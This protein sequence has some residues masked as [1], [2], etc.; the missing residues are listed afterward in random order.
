MDVSIFRAIL[1]YAVPI[2]YAIALHEAAHGY[3]AR[4]FGDRTA[5]AQGRLTLNPIKHI[6]PVGTI[7]VPG[8]LLVMAMVT[9]GPMFLFGWAKPVPVV[10]RNLRNPRRDMAIVAAAGPISNLFMATIWAI[11]I[12]I[13]SATGVGSLA[14][15]ALYSMAYV[16]ILFNVVLAVFNMLPLPPLDGGR[17]LSGLLPPRKAMIFDKIEPYGFMILIALM[18]SGVLWR[19]VGPIVDPV[20]GVFLALAGL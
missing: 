17:V 12:V 20:V 14:G 3:A 6:D 18:V 4:Y 7:L 10:V 13:G 16:G 2:L 11:I 9:G 5:E 1:L 8:A 19:I 15:D